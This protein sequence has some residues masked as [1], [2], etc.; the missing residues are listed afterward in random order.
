MRRI[1]LRLVLALVAFLLAGLGFCVSL[2]FGL[3]GIYFL[4]AEAFGPVLGAFA[5][6]GDPGWASYAPAERPAMIFAS[7]NPRVEADPFARTRAAWSSLRW[8]PGP[9][10]P[11]E[12]VA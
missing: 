2:V 4:F 1:F 7:D 9:W 6:A 3:I 12:G 10:Y 11:I 5:T 8:Q